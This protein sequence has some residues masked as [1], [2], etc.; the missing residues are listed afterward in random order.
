MTDRLCLL[1][2]LTKVFSFYFSSVWNLYWI[3]DLCQFNCFYHPQSDS[4][5]AGNYLRYSKT[6][7]PK[8][9]TFFNNR[10][11]K[12]K[13]VKIFP[14]T[15]RVLISNLN[16]LHPNWTPQ[17]H[18]HRHYRQTENTNL[19]I[20]WS[21]ILS[22]SQ[23]LSSTLRTCW[24]QFRHISLFISPLRFLNSFSTPSIV[25]LLFSRGT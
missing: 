7:W 19:S 21:I 5:S 15:I 16:Y 23:Y 13:Y 9:D 17:Y 24:I 11:T 10:E 4:I 1:M 8:I 12:F 14:N 20:F 6:Q 3:Y 2:F 18:F 22:I 25:M